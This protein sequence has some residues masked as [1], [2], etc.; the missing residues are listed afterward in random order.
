MFAIFFSDSFFCQVGTVRAAAAKAIGEV[1]VYKG[2]SPDV[3]GFAIS[4]SISSSS[5]SSARSSALMRRRHQQF[6]AITTQYGGSFV[7]TESESKSEI[8]SIDLLGLF[9]AQLAA[10]L[11]TLLA[12]TEDSK[13]ATRLQAV[14]A[15]G[16][17][18]LELLPG[19]ISCMFSSPRRP[20][21]TGPA[22]AT[23]PVHCDA[24]WEATLRAILKTVEVS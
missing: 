14:W 11:S 1:I 7:G 15:V 5:S 4:S 2:I 18:C 8:E 10:L 23:L 19:R 22:P 12:V 20:T 21:L 9:S 13:L 16:T 3:W 24:A 17:L 6:A